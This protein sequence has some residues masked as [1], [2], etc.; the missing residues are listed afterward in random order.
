MS[1]TLLNVSCTSTDPV[2]EAVVDNKELFKIIEADQQDREELIKILETNQKDLVAAGQIDY[3]QV[4]GSLSLRDEARR[5][6]VK[7]LLATGQVRTGQDFVR[8]ALVFQ[9]GN[10][11]DDILL[12][13]ILSV[14]AMSKDNVDARRMSA[15]TLDRYLHRIGQPQVFG[16]QFNSPDLAAST[17]WTMD[18]YQPDLIS[19]ALRE[20]NC[21]ESLA[22][23]Q[24]LL[25]SLRNEGELKEPTQNPCHNVE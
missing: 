24:E 10:A 9:H 5:L 25:N 11:S 19:D 18:P 8:A 20:V 12:A 22:T 1:I 4:I 2:H 7:E 15:I 13:H 17:Q 21:V 14:T 23:Q 3:E 6:K 16:T